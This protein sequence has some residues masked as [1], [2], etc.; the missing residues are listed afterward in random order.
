MKNRYKAKKNET[1][2]I[3]QA[4]FGSTRLKGKV[5]KQIVGKPMLALQIERVLRSKKL[6][7]LV[8]ATGEA[9]ENIGVVEL[10]SIL[11][12]PC[13]RGSNEDVLDRFYQC[14]VQR[15]P[16]HIVRLTGDCPLIG[17]DIVDQVVAA[18]ISEKYDYTSNLHPP[19]WPDGMDVE[20][21]TM[22]CLSDVHK[23]AN[24]PSEREHVTPFI[25]K[26]RDM[27]SI[28]N[29]EQKIDQSKFRLTV[30]EKEDFLVIKEIFES[31]Y[32]QNPFFKLDDILGLFVKKPKLLDH[33]I[34][35]S[36]NEG[37]R[38]SEMEDQRITNNA[39]Q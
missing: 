2:C 22:E 29:I 27:F 16:A 3:I 18:H 7:N 30:D 20:V 38:Q 21:I 33:N 36:R 19:T 10:C 6:D 35:F 5:L 14:A 23:K 34:R 25:Y 24:L 17:P 37:L 8:V 1:L 12:V 11:K 9:R 4:R 15:K 26:N 39:K 28:G 13:F 32:P 31:L